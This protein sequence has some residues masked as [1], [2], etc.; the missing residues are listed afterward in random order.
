MQWVN[1]QFN[2]RLADGFLPQRE[3]LPLHFKGLSQLVELFRALLA[4]FDII[5]AENC[6]E[7]LNRF[8]SEDSKVT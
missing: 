5:L 8:V 3:L 7:R 6:L 2:L 4:D 1:I